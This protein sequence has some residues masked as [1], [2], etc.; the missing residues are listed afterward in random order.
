M[1]NDDELKHALRQWKAPDAPASLERRVLGREPHRQA[2]WRWLLTG[3]V[4]IPVPALIAFA[5]IAVA[6]YA[7]RVSKAPISCAAAPE[8]IILAMSCELSDAPSSS[9]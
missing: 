8:Q 1:L 3:S 9:L 5:A 6:V 2:W 7:A 4:R